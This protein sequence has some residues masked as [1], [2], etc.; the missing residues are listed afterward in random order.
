[1]SNYFLLCVAVCVIGGLI[2][3]IFKAGTP[4]E[5]FATL[6]FWAYILGMAATLLMIGGHIVKLP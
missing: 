6:G 4:S 2:Y 3:L 1:M 5:K